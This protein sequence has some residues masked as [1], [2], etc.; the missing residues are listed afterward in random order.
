MHFHEG[1]FQIADRDFYFGKQ[2]DSLEQEFFL[3][4]KQLT[5][6]SGQLQCR[7]P[8]RYQWLMQLRGVAELNLSRCEALNQ[9]LRKVPA[10]SVSLVFSSEN[11]SKPSSMMGHIL[12]K[13]DGRIGDRSASH[14]ISYYTELNSINL[15][16]IIYD[17]LIVGKEGFFVLSPYAEKRNYYLYDEGRNIW[18]YR[19]ELTDSAIARLLLHM[20]ELKQTQLPYFFDDYNC[21]TLTANLLGVADT[22]LL[23]YSGSW[24]TPLDVV[25][26][27]NHSGLIAST[28]IETAP[29]WRARMLA[30]ALSKQQVRSVIRYL[31]TGQFD[32]PLADNSRE[33]QFLMLKLAHEYNKVSA[34]TEA[35]LSGLPDAEQQQLNALTTEFSIDLSEYKSPLDTPHDS[36]IS[37]GIQHY[38]SRMFARL[39]YLPT[40]HDIDDDNRQYFTEN[41]LKLG[42]I[43]VLVNER[44]LKL[45]TLTL[46]EAT[47]LSP[48]DPWLGSL[49]GHIHLGFRRAYNDELQRKLNF[50]ISGGVG[51]SYE[52][53]RQTK[54]YGLLIGGA[55]VSADE[56]YGYL[57]PE[58]GLIVN[59]RGDMKTHVN[60]R[61]SVNELNN[62]NNLWQISVRQMKYFSEKFS[63]R[64]KY[65]WIFN[66][67]ETDRVWQL[68]LK[69][70]F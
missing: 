54:L 9:Y 51:K 64:L 53:L 26:H 31:K 32:P 21:A 69:H 36:Q 55:G 60:A 24:L 57:A 66:E 48:S 23:N 25:K 6:D 40:A 29:K 49:S 1:S 5:A 52:P 10:Q 59:E 34:R 44:S 19:L 22:R 4:Q 14:A 16:K 45:E 50:D 18:E 3:A 27:V 43:S 7:F 42:Y 15:L 28:T 61:Y 35:K 58:L 17:S 37:V 33:Q 39:T 8:A 67:T 38:N 65:S 47:S 62:R 20:W 13:I 68:D 41:A 63:I 56:T 46:Y 12:L 30:D 11:V 70:H 2:R